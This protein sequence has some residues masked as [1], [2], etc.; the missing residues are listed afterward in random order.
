MDLRF[1]SPLL[2]SVWIVWCSELGRLCVTLPFVGV[3]R[4]LGSR[5]FFS[6]HVL[7]LSTSGA[8]SQLCYSVLRGSAPLVLYSMLQLSGR[9]A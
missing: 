9:S 7:G 1:H 2:V 8:E 3:C 6:Q 4:D 5:G